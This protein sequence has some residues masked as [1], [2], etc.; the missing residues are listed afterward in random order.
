MAQEKQD[1]GLSGLEIIAI[2]NQNYEGLA[3]NLRVAQ[4]FISQNYTPDKVLPL[5]R[6]QE[7]LSDAANDAYTWL[8]ATHNG[9]VVATI[10]Y[11]VLPVP[12]MPLDKRL[13]ADG[14]THYTALFYATAAQ[15][16]DNALQQ[17]LSKVKEDA[18]SYS[19][20]KGKKNAGMLTD[21]TKH[22][23]VIERLGGVVLGEIGVPSLEDI[24]DEDYP[25]K[26]FEEA[27]K[28]TLMF[29]PFGNRRI[30]NSL[31]TRMAGEFINGY[32][33]KVPGQDMYVPLTNAGYFK[34]FAESIGTGS[35][36]GRFIP[37]TVQ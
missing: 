20:I 27:G 15:G 30:T 37:R 9:N 24:R 36:R 2:N 12:R 11:D 35:P 5:S 21:D 6:A 29:I 4:E 23:D 7:S 17:L 3:D 33:E 8:V 22:K 18:V 19:G 14:K 16:Y 10:V 31:I 34:K 1:N 28:E 32:N 13:V 26:N 25:Q